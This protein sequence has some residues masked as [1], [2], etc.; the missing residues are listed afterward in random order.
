MRSMP[1]CLHDS[2]G[3]IG[4]QKSLFALRAALLSLRRSQT[5]ESKM[6]ERM[7]R[8]LYEKKGLGYAK[9]VA[10]MGPKWGIDPVLDLSGQTE[11]VLIAG[12]WC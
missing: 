5:R 10:D 1:Y 4:A 7:Y 11:L 3:L 8:E 12:A 9:Q 6:C 2:M